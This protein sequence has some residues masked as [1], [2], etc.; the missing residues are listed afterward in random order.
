[1]LYRAFTILCLIVASAFSLA[2]A[3]T[4]RA[5]IVGVGAYD[6]LTDLRK[7]VGD[8]NGY[9]TLFEDSLGFEVTRLT[10]SQNRRD[11][12]AAFDQFVRSI[13]PEDEVAFVFSGHGWS[14]GSDN[15]LSFAD[16][17][18][19]VSEAVLQSETIPLQRMVMARLRA[20]NPK[21]ILAII[22]ACRDEQY[23]SLTRSTGALDKGI[24]RISANE[25]ELILYSSGAGQ[26]SLDRLSD[27]DPS[28]YSVFTREL[29]PRLARTDRPLAT[30]ADETRTAVQ[31]QA[32]TISHPQ[33]PEMMLGIGLNFCLSGSC[34]TPSGS[35]LL[36]AD[37]ELWLE[38]TRTKRSGASC[39]DYRR[40]LA[41]FPDGAFAERARGLLGVPPC[42]EV[43]T[44]PKVPQLTSTVT[45]GQAR[46][47]I[48]DARTTPASTRAPIITSDPASLPDFALFRECEACPDMVVI[49]GGNFLMGSPASEEGRFDDEGPQQQV[50]I[51]RFAV[52]RFETTWDEWAACVSAGACNQGPLEEAGGD[53]GWGKGRRPVINVDWNDAR[54]FGR[55]LEGPTPGKYRLPTE[56]EWE[57][58]ARAGTQTRF[59]WGEG[60]PRCDERSRLGA[61]Y[62]NC[63]DNRTRPVGSFQVS[64]FGLYDAHGNVWEWVEGCWNSSLSGQP[65]DGAANTAGNCANRV[66]R[67]GSWFDSPR[68]LRSAYRN[69]NN[70]EV[71]DSN[72]GFRLARDLTD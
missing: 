51:T 46:N 36:D 47:V 65:P 26:T 29:L 34:A 69:R 39:D 53:V 27:A 4:K 19:G 3:Q 67:G 37:T 24:V 9:E 55:F 7:T 54:A 30:I 2:D 33:R 59:Y 50:T 22:D 64:P 23:G 10:G 71:R 1:M 61:N 21:L 60:E 32:G 43:A 58:A 35:P 62:F 18:R 57:Y 6:E 70:Q 12:V 44:S 5:F 15:Y 45:A 48:F 40:Y 38:V 25:G 20:Q 56:A 52:S 13:S 28:P 66:R 11:F 8:A 41:A 14:D 68:N 16:T 72:V 17:P 42:A 31:R 49:P 63:S